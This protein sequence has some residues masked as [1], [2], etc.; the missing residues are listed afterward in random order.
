MDTLISPEALARRMRGPDAPR[1]LDVRRTG[2]REAFEAAH[3]PGAVYVDL[4]SELA[5]PADDPARGGRHPLPDPEAFA[6]RVGRV[7]GITPETAV[8]AMDDAR[9]ALAAAR[10]WW[11]LRALGHRSVA[12]LDGGLAAAR[13]AG[14]PMDA[15]RGAQPTPAPP[16]P[17]ARPGEWALPTVSLEQ[18]EVLRRS[19]THRLLDARSAARFRGD[20]E[21]LDPV[22]GHIDGA[23]SAPYET[24]NL[25]PETGR[26]LPPEELA[27]RYRALLAGVPPTE[28]VAQCGSGVT[29]CHT[30]LGMAHAGLPGAALYVGSWS[31]WCRRFP[32]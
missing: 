21:P 19:P 7:W 6:E 14:L 3:L 27:R 30:L 13:D 23:V 20:E 4:D 26:F 17:R 15:G 25:D 16:Y 22:A 32:S 8:V 5:A 10:L 18:V 2:G 1:I 9:G 11:M 12:V 31:E 28:A 24:T 29:A